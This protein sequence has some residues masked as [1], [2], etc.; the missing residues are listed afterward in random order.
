MA[1]S[2]SGIEEKT[3]NFAKSFFFKRFIMDSEHDLSMK[4]ILSPFHH[5][6]IIYS[7]LENFPIEM[8]VIA[9]AGI[10]FFNVHNSFYMFVL[11]FFSPI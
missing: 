2:A 6:L 1:H 5:Q 8:V 7:K 9:A 10:S 4:W 3:E 11:F